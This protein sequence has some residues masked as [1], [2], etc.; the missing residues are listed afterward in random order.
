[1]KLLI[2]NHIKHNHP[3]VCIM[4]LY[5]F[6][7]IAIPA[8]ANINNGLMGYYPLNGSANDSSN[9]GNH[10]TI[11]SATATTDRFGNASGALYFDGVDDY[12][13]IDTPSSLDT[14]YSISIFAWIN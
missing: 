3:V 12:V 13:Q 7:C 2:I 14:R 5:L 8:Y 10:G 1:M 11:N 4:L 6:L 9:Y